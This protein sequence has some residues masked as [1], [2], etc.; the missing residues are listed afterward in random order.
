[1][2][3][4]L[5]V[6]ETRDVRMRVRLDIGTVRNDYSYMN[7]SSIMKERNTGYKKPTFPIIYRV[8]RALYSRNKAYTKEYGREI[9]NM[10][11]SGSCYGIWQLHI[12]Y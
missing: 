10:K 4:L 7:N 11:G 6:T 5:Y 9:Y 8:F 1:M 2:S 12:G 3:S